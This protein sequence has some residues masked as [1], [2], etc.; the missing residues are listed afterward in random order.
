MSPWICFGKQLFA[1]GLLSRDELI[2]IGQV[3]DVHN[4]QCA[5]LVNRNAAPV[6]TPELAGVP[7]RRPE[8]HGGK[9]AFIRGGLECYSGSRADQRG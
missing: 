7:Q 9:H 1:I 8:P 2:A 5:L 6:Y 4:Q 3:V